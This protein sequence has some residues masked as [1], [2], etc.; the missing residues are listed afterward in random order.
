MAVLEIDRNLLF[1]AWIKQSSLDA[2]TISHV[3]YNQGDDA[4]NNHY[5]I[6]LYQ[7]D[8]YINDYDY[9]SSGSPGSDLILQTDRKFRDTSAWMNIIV[10]VDTTES[11]AADRVRVYINGVQETSFS[12]ATYPDENADLHVMNQTSQSTGVDTSAVHIGRYTNNIKSDCYM[13][14]INYCDG[15]SLAPSNFSETKDGIWI[16]KNT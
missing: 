9:G 3:L 10:R 11:T 2:S 16:P 5:Y 6:V 1:H 14:D 7:D 12:T 15:Q 8:I 4:G 13:A